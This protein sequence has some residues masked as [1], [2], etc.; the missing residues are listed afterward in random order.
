MNNDEGIKVT[1]T[2]WG[3]TSKRSQ[4]RWRDDLNEDRKV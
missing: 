4:K 1:A 3:L 2:Q